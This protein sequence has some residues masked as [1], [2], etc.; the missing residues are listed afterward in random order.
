MELPIPDSLLHFFVAVAIVVV[1]VVVVVVWLEG[2]SLPSS[3][4][5]EGSAS[6]MIV[7]IFVIG[8]ATIP[9]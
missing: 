5:S 7:W 9:S 4:S 3:P 1:V 8:P 6:G 2:A